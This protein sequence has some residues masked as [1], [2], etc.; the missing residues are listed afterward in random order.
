MLTK[1]NIR[2]V[3]T[4]LRENTIHDNKIF[5]GQFFMM[6]SNQGRNERGKGGTIPRSPNRYGVAKW[7]PEA[8]KS[9]NNFLQYS[10][11]ASVRPQVRTRHGVITSQM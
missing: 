11:F 1:T 9:P 4:F 6:C 3:Q 2:S 8:S 5:R 10:K 7:L